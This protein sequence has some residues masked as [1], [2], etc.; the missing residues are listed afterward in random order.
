M[1]TK[2]NDAFWRWFGESQ[3]VDENGKPLLLYHGTH[4]NFEKFARGKAAVGNAIMP[5]RFTHLT[6]TG[7]VL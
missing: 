4:K 6:T 3:V 5:T 7:R 2:F 1:A